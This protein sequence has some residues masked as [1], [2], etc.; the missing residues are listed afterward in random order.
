MILFISPCFFEEYIWFFLLS[1]SDCRRIVR[2][3]TPTSLQTN[4]PVACAE[5]FDDW[6]KNESGCAVPAF[7]GNPPGVRRRRTDVQAVTK[8]Q[9]DLFT[10]ETFFASPQTWKWV[11]GPMILYVC[12]RLVRIYRSH[13]KVVI[14]KARLR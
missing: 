11:L 3:Q 5:H 13:Q 9:S 1:V 6:G 10:P 4:N 14:T 8:L 12:E 2:G 7:A